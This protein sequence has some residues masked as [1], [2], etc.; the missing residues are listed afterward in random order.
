MISITALRAIIILGRVLCQGRERHVAF[1][2]GVYFA[3]LLLRLTPASPP[4]HAQEP[5]E[6]IVFAA[7]SL[8]DAFEEIGA[9]FEAENPGV[10][11]LFNFASSSDLAAQLAEGA[12]AD[13]FA[14]ANARQMTVAREAGRT[15]GRARIFARN[16]LILIVPA[17][18][19]ARMTELRDLAN[20]DVQLIVAAP[21]VPVRTYTDTMLERLAA[22]PTYGEA[23]RAAV[24]FAG[25]PRELED[26]A[27]VDGAGGWSLFR[28]ITLPL[29]LRALAA[30]L[31]LAWARA[32][33]EFGATILFAGSLQ[34][35]TQTMPLLIYNVIERDIDAAI[36]T[37]L[38]LVG[39]ALAALL[40]VGWL[41]R[42]ER[43]ED[44][45]VM[46]RLL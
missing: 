33:G 31:V 10:E 12:P 25:V 37:G 5:G 18:N 45:E 4:A 36:W 29:A 19:P 9:A 44:S 22:D 39:I 27:R 46:T 32:L 41:R 42:K 17:D 11:V 14:S 26:A 38:I 13:I 6:L 34:G 43:E 15:A 23:Y 7:A 2:H 1:T 24:G 20:D 30:G 16:R 21:D 28:A 35:R 3:F 40:V 8:S